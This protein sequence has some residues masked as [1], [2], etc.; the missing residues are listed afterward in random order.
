MRLLERCQYLF[1]SSAETNAGGSLN[2]PQQ[3]VSSDLIRIHVAHLDVV[4]GHVHLPGRVVREV[5]LV[6]R[7]TRGEPVKPAVAQTDGG[8][9]GHDLER[10]VLG[11]VGEESAVLNLGA[12]HVFHALVRVSGG[13]VLSGGGKE[14]MPKGSEGKG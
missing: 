9:G 3:A 14:G 2:F 8:L 11:L 5:V 1:Q 6:G 4:N 13:G 7:V 10:G 12:R